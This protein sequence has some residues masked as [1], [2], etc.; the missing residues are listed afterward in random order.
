MRL[1]GLLMKERAMMSRE[2]LLE[3]G[4]HNSRLGGPALWELDPSITKLTA[5]LFGLG[6]LVLSPE[7]FIPP[8]MDVHI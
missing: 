7:V 5:D 4:R 6:L 1:R 3:D 2:M 8:S